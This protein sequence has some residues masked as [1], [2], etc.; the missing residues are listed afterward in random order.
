MKKSNVNGEK[1]QPINDVVYRDVRNR[2]ISRPT[3][4]SAARVIF[5]TRLNIGWLYAGTIMNKRTVTLL[6]HVN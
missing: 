2:Q 1:T 6:G 4:D 3:I 5:L